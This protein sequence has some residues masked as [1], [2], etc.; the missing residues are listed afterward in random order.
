[1]S[2]LIKADQV[3]KLV[4]ERFLDVL[5]VTS[6]LYQ[7]RA[8]LSS[9]IYDYVYNLLLLEYLTGNLSRSQVKLVSNL[10]G[11]P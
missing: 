9:A 4:P 5:D 3:L 8:R 6:N 1:M 11:V 2:C 7:A 10:Y